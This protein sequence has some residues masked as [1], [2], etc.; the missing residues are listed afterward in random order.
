MMLQYLNMMGCLVDIEEDED[1]EEGE[2]GSTCREVE[3]MKSCT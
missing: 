2:E 1:D 3:N